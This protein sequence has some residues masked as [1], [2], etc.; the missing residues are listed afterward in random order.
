LRRWEVHG[1]EDYIPSVPQIASPSPDPIDTEVLA[2]ELLPRALKLE[3]IVLEQEADENCQRYAASAGKDYLFDFEESGLLVRRAP[4]AGT[5]QIV[6][7]KS[8]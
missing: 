7:P 6:F 4:L 3:E 1:L 5:M 8:L 2:V